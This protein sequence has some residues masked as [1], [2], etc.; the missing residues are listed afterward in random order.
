MVI[1]S[2]ILAK[3]MMKIGDHLHAA[4]LLCRVA[5]F[6]SMFPKHVV[7]ILTSVVMECARSGLK[8]AAYQ[9]SLVLAKPENR[10]QISEKYKK[11]IE[12][13]ARKPVKVQDDP[14]PSSPCPFCKNP[15]PD[16]DV[17]CKSCK[18]CVPFCI[19]S[20]KHMTW[21]DWGCCPSC[22][23]PAIIKEFHRVL[24]AE[25][26]CPMCDKEV[27]PASIMKVKEVEE[28]LK[29]FQAQYVEETEEP[30]DEELE[31][32]LNEMLQ[33]QSCLLYTS[34]AADDT[35]CVDLGGRRIIKKKKKTKQNKQK[36]SIHTN[37]T[38]Q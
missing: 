21:S 20:G 4:R 5:N 25:A 6:I 8:Y 22:K 1:H 33:Q 32:G 30:G 3:R 37:Y 17:D 26:I 18:N 2:Y 31:V 38:K 34:D 29:S 9:W 19:A 11:K 27:F 35:P 14:E 13:I 10:S 28:E 7:P 15:L 36:T 12:D 23:L 16:L 24:E